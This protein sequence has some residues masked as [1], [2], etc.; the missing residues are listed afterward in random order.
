MTY[1]Q[2]NIHPGQV[3]PDPNQDPNNVNPH[4]AY[5]HGHT[6]YPNQMYYSYPNQPMTVAPVRTITQEFLISC[7]GFLA[8]S[9]FLER[10]RMEHI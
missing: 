4:M 9:Q 5:Y 8:I 7:S 10:I 6:M 3:Y 2:M 1:S